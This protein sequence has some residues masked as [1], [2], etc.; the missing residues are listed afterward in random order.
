MHDLLDRGK[1]F[2]RRSE[3]D[4]VESPVPQNARTD[5]PVNEPE[6]GVVAEYP[7]RLLQLGEID[8][9]SRYPDTRDLRQLMREPAV[10][11]AHLEDLQH[12]SPGS[13]VTDKPPRRSFP[14]LP[15]VVMG[16]VRGY[17]G[18]PEQLFV[19]IEPALQSPDLDIFLF[20]QDLPE[21]RMALDL[22][23]R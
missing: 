11:A 17:L 6:I 14:P 20:K 23:V 15:L 9:R 18:Q 8:I 21:P 19:G 4:N 22:Y 10:A 1:M 7:C 3:N 2:D 13:Q 5:I 12:P 16:M